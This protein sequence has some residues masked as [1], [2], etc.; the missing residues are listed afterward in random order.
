[1][2]DETEVRARIDLKTIVTIV[3]LVAMGSG[4]V[5]SWATNKAEVA[6]LQKSYTELQEDY[7]N[8][9]Q[10]TDERIVDMKIEI[11]SSTSDVKAIK[12]VVGEIKEDVKKLLGGR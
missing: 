7:K 2:A 11:T 12:E 9:K 5:A 1:M 6:S 10:R 3:T 8:Y 4:L